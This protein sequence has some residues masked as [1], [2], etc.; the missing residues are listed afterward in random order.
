MVWKLQEENDALRG[1][2][3]VLVQSMEE[4]STPLLKYDYVPYNNT[5]TTTTKTC[6]N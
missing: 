5:I 2:L 3:A 6:I 1:L 4:E